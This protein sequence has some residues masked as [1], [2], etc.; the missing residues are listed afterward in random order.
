M[1]RTAFLKDRKLKNEEGT[2]KIG[3]PEWA[4]G[5]LRKSYKDVEAALLGEQGNGQ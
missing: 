3:K 1:Y 5:L 4:S 2:M